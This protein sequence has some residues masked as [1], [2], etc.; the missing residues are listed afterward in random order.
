MSDTTAIILALVPTISTTV[1]TIMIMLNSA[2][3]RRSAAKLEK[4]AD[5]IAKSKA[6][7]ELLEKN[8]NSIKDALV[9]VTG[10]SEFAKGLLAAAEA[11]QK[12]A[13]PSAEAGSI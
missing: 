8:T 12:P 5:H 4:M 11:A 2:I 13:N 9:K 3:A 7:M 10:E 1:G 6:A